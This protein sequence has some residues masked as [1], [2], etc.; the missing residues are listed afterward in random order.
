MTFIPTYTCLRMQSFNSSRLRGLMEL[1]SMRLTYSRGF[2]VG[3]VSW[4]RCPGFYDLGSAAP[5][6]A[7]V[8]LL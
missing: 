3:E 2:R 7:F 6:P 8:D 4:S 1:H 5:K